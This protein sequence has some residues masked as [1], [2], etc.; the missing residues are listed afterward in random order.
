[1]V[2]ADTDDVDEILKRLKK[3]LERVRAVPDRR[4]FG[5]FCLDLQSAVKKTEDAL[6]QVSLSLRFEGLF[7]TSGV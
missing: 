2:R 1:M 4:L 6:V 3:Q 5:M 7:Y